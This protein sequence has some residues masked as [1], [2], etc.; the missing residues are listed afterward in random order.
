MLLSRYLFY[1]WWLSCRLQEAACLDWA[2]VPCIQMGT[3]AILCHLLDPHPHPFFQVATP[4]ALLAQV[5]Y[6]MPCFYWGSEML[7]MYRGTESWYLSNLCTWSETAGGRLLCCCECPNP[8]LLFSRPVN[9]CGCFNHEVMWQELK[10]GQERE[11]A[12]TVYDDWRRWNLTGTFSSQM[13]QS[14]L[15]FHIVRKSNEN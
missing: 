7:G 10:I 13:I 5:C 14:I 2:G 6:V 12:G 8:R 11:W 15:V 4:V 1:Q 9:M 3:S